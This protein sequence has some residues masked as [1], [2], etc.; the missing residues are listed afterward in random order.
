MNCAGCEHLD[1]RY[2]EC[3]ALQHMA[4]CCFQAVEISRGGKCQ[5]CGGYAIT[6]AAPLKIAD[7]GHQASAHCPLTGQERERLEAK[8]AAPVQKGLF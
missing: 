5:T 4:V 7:G 6:P 3:L 2:G 1:K 8:Q